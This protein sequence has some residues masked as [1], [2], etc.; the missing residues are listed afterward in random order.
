MTHIWLVYNWIQDCDLRSRLTDRI[1]IVRSVRGRVIGSR[2]WDRIRIV[3]SDQDRAIGSRHIIEIE[4]LNRDRDRIGPRSLVRFVFSL[5]NHLSIFTYS[6]LVIH[7][8]TIW[9]VWVYDLKLFVSS[10][11]CRSNFSLYAT[12]AGDLWVYTPDSTV[13][14]CDRFITSITTIHSHDRKFFRCMDGNRKNLTGKTVKNAVKKYHS[15]CKVLPLIFYIWT[16]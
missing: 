9:Y 10:T 12:N 5:R 16:L 1:Q 13:K 11:M 2:S 14:S 7:D 15:H 3:R 6:T 8:L 4:T